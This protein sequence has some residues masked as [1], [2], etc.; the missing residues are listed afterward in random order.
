MAGTCKNKIAIFYYFLLFVMF[1]SGPGP[2]IWIYVENSVK[3]IQF[4]NEEYVINSKKSI[5]NLKIYLFLFLYYFSF[6]KCVDK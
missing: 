1:V 5:I 3:F 6:K 4:K 2:V